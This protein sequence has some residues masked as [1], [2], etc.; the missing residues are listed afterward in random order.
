MYMPAANKCRLGSEMRILLLENTRLTQEAPGRSPS[1]LK[2]SCPHRCIYR[3]SLSAPQNQKTAFYLSVTTLTFHFQNTRLTQEAPGR[4][5]S[6]LKSSCPHRCIYRVSLSAPQNQKTAFY[7][8]ATT[9]TFHFQNQRQGG[10]QEI[11]Q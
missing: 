5:P 6:S 8:S 1:S 10:G 3:V 4:S 2:S 11:F 7:L 9:L